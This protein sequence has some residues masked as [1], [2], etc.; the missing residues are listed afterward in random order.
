MSLQP[1]KLLGQVLEGD[2][3]LKELLGEGGMGFVFR[4]YQRSLNRLV[5]VKFMHAHP[6]ANPEWAERFRR[7]SLALSAMRDEGVVTLYSVGIYR[8]VH[9]Y[10]VMEHVDGQ[11]LRQMIDKNGQLDSRQACTIFIQV[12]GALSRLH[13]RGFVHRDLKPDNIICRDDGVAKI[14]DFGL[15]A[16]VESNGGVG[17]DTVTRT[18]DLIGT[19]NYLAPECFKESQRAHSADIYALGCTFYESLAGKPLFAAENYAA[20]AVIHTSSPIPKLPKSVGDR[21]EREFLDFIVQGACAKN[22]A[23]RPE[24]RQMHEQF[25]AF[26]DTAPD[27]LK[28]KIPPEQNRPESIRRRWSVAL[29]TF[30]MIVAAFIGHASSKHTHRTED[31][32]SSDVRRASNDESLQH[33]CEK[34]VVVAERRVSFDANNAPKALELLAAQYPKMPSIKKDALIR[35][36]LKLLDKAPPDYV[37]DQV[38]SHLLKLA[39]FKSAERKYSEALPLF[40][41]ALSTMNQ[42][43]NDSLV[44]STINEIGRILLLQNNTREARIY[45]EKSV[46]PTERLFGHSSNAMLHL[47]I[48]L[49]RLALKDGQVTEATSF[50]TKALKI[51]ARDLGGFAGEMIETAMC[52]QDKGEHDS[53]EKILQMLLGSSKAS[54]PPETVLHAQTRLACTY[55]RR[56]MYSMA[57]PLL[58]ETVRSAKNLPGISPLMKSDNLCRLA[59]CYLLTKNVAEAQSCAKQA[60]ALCQGDKRRTCD[61]LILLSKCYSN[62]EDK[63]KTL[64]LAEATA[65]KNDLSRTATVLFN[66]G[67]FYYK[68]GRFSQAKPRLEKSF[69]ACLELNSKE[70]SALTNHCALLLGNIYRTELDYGNAER[71][72]ESLRRYHKSN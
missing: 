41:R 45:Y 5:C 34:S 19:P 6:G 40:K 65:T 9:P 20:V 52:F 23:M 42:Q 68:S 43:G 2:I 14:L 48:R 53:A 13:L 22:P 47:Y 8:G 55:Y 56:G 69:A 16:L 36:T 25:A 44:V 50:L 38:A 54:L 7:E 66:L 26:L 12:C 3:E 67:L 61:N 62:P 17:F 24:A 70:F 21:D 1:E 59:G 15:C 18:N 58:E 63:E 33:A 46:R 29:I 27:G 39:S 72:E 51:P 57:S 37:N 49:S 30:A 28:G 31:V 11:T 10:F 64:L 4:G 32:V 71:I 35:R 60:L